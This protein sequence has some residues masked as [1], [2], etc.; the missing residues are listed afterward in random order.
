MRWLMALMVMTLC[1]PEL[2][3]QEFKSPLLMGYGPARMPH[4]PKAEARQ[5]G[6]PGEFVLRQKYVE[7]QYFRDEFHGWSTG[8]GMWRGIAGS[9]G[10]PMRPAMAALEGTSNPEADFMAMMQAGWLDQEQI[11]KGFEVKRRHDRLLAYARSKLAVAQAEGEP[12][13]IRAARRVLADMDRA[14]YLEKKA[15]MAG[16]R[17]A[18]RKR[19]PDLLCSGPSCGQSPSTRAPGFGGPPAPPRPVMPPPPPMGA[20]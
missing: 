2:A 6:Y 20:P 8:E 9:G 18:V 7:N 16:V 13:K 5:Q 15:F 17:A 10:G 14:H 19:R 3:A 12:M 11:T 1:V 4:A